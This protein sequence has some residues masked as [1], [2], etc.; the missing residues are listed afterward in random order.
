MRSILSSTAANMGREEDFSNRLLK[1]GSTGSVVDHKTNRKSIWWSGEIHR[2]TSCVIRQN[3]FASLLWTCTLFTILI[4]VWKRKNGRFPG[5]VFIFLFLYIYIYICHERL[6]LK[7]HKLHRTKIQIH[8]IFV[9]SLDVI[10]TF[11]SFCCSTFSKCFSNI[12]SF[13]WAPQIFWL[14]AKGGGCTRQKSEIDHTSHVRINL[15]FE[16]IYPGFPGSNLNY[17][18]TDYKRQIIFWQI[19][20][21]RKLNLAK[22][23][24]RSI[25]SLAK[26]N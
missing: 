6:S 24:L 20:D 18:I 21:K 10:E 17:C 7:C 2:N 15:S 9:S 19:I 11:K 16:L 1:N 23:L 25:M 8:D 5:C 26:I 13:I 4:E 3:S 22:T 12:L 14:S